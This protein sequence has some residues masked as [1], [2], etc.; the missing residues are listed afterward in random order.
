MRSGSGAWPWAEGDFGEH[1]VHLR[2]AMEA[3]RRGR[4]DAGRKRMGR[5]LALAMAARGGRGRGG[6][7]AREDAWGP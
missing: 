6:A 5:M 2:V 4:R 3:S 1:L 7:V